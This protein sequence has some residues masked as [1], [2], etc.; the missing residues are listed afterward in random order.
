MFCLNQAQLT[1]RMVA[2]P[3]SRFTSTGTPIAHFRLAVNRRYQTKDG[4]DREEVLFLDCEA[5]SKAAEHIC[6]HAKKGHPVFVS[7]RL[8]LDQWEKDDQRRSSIVLVV[9][10]FHSLVYDKKSGSDPAADSA[11]PNSFREMAPDHGRPTATDAEIP[12]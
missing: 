8:R 7:G 6:A 5:W 2:D 3:D 1:G 10:R 9:E 12:F 11:P 4:T